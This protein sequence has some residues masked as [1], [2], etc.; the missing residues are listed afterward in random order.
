MLFLVTKIIKAELN[1]NPM[2]GLHFK[3][4]SLYGLTFILAKANEKIKIMVNKQLTIIKDTCG[5]EGLSY[6]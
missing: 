5:V 4:L 6:K 1:I 2:T 3:M